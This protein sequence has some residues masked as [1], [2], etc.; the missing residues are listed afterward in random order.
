MP[1]LGGL[2]NLDLINGAFFVDLGPDGDIKDKLQGIRRSHSA[3]GSTPQSQNNDD[4]IWNEVRFF[5][6]FKHF[7]I[8]LYNEIDLSLY[9]TN[10]LFSYDLPC[11]NGQ[12]D[13]SILKKIRV[14]QGYQVQ[15]PSFYIYKKLDN[16]VVYLLTKKNRGG[17]QVI[18]KTFNEVKV[19]EIVETETIRLDILVFKFFEGI[20]ERVRDSAEADTVP[21]FWDKNTKKSIADWVKQR[22]EDFE[23][24]KW[25]IGDQKSSKIFEKY[26]F[27]LF[28]SDF[29]IEGRISK[30][31]RELDSTLSM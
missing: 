30:F 5:W 28:K 29:D 25:L 6:R 10:L 14:S 19:C 7:S 18:I 8:P 15:N 2:P 9:E 31:F 24:L 13:L 21:P 17:C 27:H 1:F 22:K 3:S 4:S 16:F 26:T 11:L 12:Y 20:F 23:F